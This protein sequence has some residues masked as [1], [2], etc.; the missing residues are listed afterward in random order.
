MNATT[1]RQANWCEQ[2]PELY[3]VKEID[4]IFSLKIY[5]K[6]IAREMSRHIGHILVSAVFRPVDRTF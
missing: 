1:S 4:E 6:G 2:L 3:F 5:Y